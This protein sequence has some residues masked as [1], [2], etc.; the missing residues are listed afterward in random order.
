MS[1]KL[2]PLALGHKEEL[3]FLGRDLG[4]QRN[5]SEE[6]AGEIDQEVQ[7]IINRAY[8]R[9]KQILTDR[10]DKLEAIAEHL[11][12]VETIDSAELDRLLAEP[13]HAPEPHAKTA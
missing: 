1:E 12:V 7:G 2:G 3:V 8:S 11:K 5:Y 9:A 13:T 10:R 6:V 4:E